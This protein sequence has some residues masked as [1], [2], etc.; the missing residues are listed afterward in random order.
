MSRLSLTLAM[1]LLLIATLVIGVVLATPS[2]PI[3]AAITL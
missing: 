1:A 3:P 2:I